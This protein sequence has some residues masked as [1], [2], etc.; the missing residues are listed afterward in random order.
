MAFDKMEKDLSAGGPWLLGNELSLA[1]INMMPFVARVEY[2]ALLDVWLAERPA[3]RAW[4]ARVQA[5]P[6]F[7][8]SIPKKLPDEDVQAMRK[9][10]EKIRDRVA[11]RRDEYLR[12]CRP[13]PKAA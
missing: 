3:S 10:G 9:S 1:D 5:L 4:W 13:L 6:S 12:T 2:L 11:A 8:A 7:V